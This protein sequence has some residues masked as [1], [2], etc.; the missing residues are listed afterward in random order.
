MPNRVHA[1]LT[2]V[3]RPSWSSGTTRHATAN[4]VHAGLAAGVTLVELGHHETRDNSDTR[5]LIGFTPAACAAVV[6]LVEPGHREAVGACQGHDVGAR[7][8]P[9]IRDGLGDGLHEARGGSPPPLATP[10][11]TPWRPLSAEGHI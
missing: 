3:V 1:G 10:P 4:R 8:P 6:T 9:S 2:A 7:G 5:P 11:A